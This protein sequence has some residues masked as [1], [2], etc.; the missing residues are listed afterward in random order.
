MTVISIKILLITYFLIFTNFGLEQRVEQIGVNL[1]L[2]LFF[3]LWVLIILS[4]FAVSFYGTLNAR[5]FWGLFFSLSAVLGSIYYQSSGGQYLSFNTIAPIWDAKG[6]IFDALILYQFI[7][8]KSIINSFAGL[9]GIIIP[10]TINKK[11]IKFTGLIP[12]API[13][14]ISFIIF[15][16]GGEG[17]GGLPSQLIPLTTFSVY[18]GD[19]LLNQENPSREQVSISIYQQPRINNIVLVVDESVRAD[20]LKINDNKKGVDTG[21][22]NSNHIANFGW[23]SASTSCSIYSNLGLM[24]GGNKKATV[25][26]IRTKPSIWAYAKSAGFETYFIGGQK[27]TPD[28]NKWIDYNHIDYVTTNGDLIND[29]PNLIDYEIARKTKKIIN[30]NNNNKLIYVIKRGSHFPYESRYPDHQ[31]IF[32][33]HMSEGSVFSPQNTVNERADLVINSYKN[34]VQWNT[35]IFFKEYFSEKLKHSTALFYTSDHGQKLKSEDNTSFFTHCN[36]AMVSPFE[37]LVPLVIATN[38][39]ALHQLFYDAAKRN[40]DKSGHLNIFPTILWTLGYNV[41]DI[42]QHY[43]QSLLDDIEGIQQFVSPPFFT[44]FGRKQKLNSIPK[45]GITAIIPP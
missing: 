44:K 42:N 10:S 45:R 3:A 33:P 9:I 41:K 20:Y 15:I 25:N 31:A 27:L 16:R 39:L 6:N 40:Y 21:L 19:N 24:Y 38:D 35:G 5:I 43:A 29:D 18:M 14:L 36:T 30:A 11:P 22:S 2:L 17:T 26:I 37:G 1:N 32:S 13:I 28:D 23:S 8:I 4:I 12:L 7:V 34:S